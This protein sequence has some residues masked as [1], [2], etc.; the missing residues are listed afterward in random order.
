[1]RHHGSAHRASRHSQTPASIGKN[2]GLTP[3]TLTEASRRQDR[4]TPRLHASQGQEGR[5]GGGPRVRKGAMQGPDGRQLTPCPATDRLVQP[6]ALLLAARHPSTHPD[7]RSRPHTS[8]LQAEPSPSPVTA[9][10]P[11]AVPGSGPRSGGRRRGPPTS[12]PP[13]SPKHA[14]VGEPGSSEQPSKKRRKERR[15]GDGATTSAAAA[16]AAAPPADVFPPANGGDALSPLSPAYEAGPGGA[17]RA[18]DR[19]MEAVVKVFTVH[20]EPNFS[21]VR[22]PAA[23]PSACCRLRAAC[24]SAWP[25]PVAMLARFPAVSLP[26]GMVCWHSRCRWLPPAQLACLPQLL[27]SAA[28]AAAAAAVQQRQQAG[29]ASFPDP[30]LL[31]PCCP[32]S[33]GSASGSTAAAAAAL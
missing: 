14:A 28:S 3:G 9:A 19:L 17:R 5:Q 26:C 8:P 11:P 22:A 29:W 12:E 21:L 2:H 16:A 4:P 30:R 13:V 7:H 27:Y 18:D 10:A 15:P 31:P 20:S 6:A 24:C 32:C 33:P 23:L 1:M 25:T